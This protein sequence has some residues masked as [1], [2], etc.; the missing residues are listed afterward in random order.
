MQRIS[1]WGNFLSCTYERFFFSFLRK[2]LALLPRLECSGVILA[3]CKHYLPGLG[4]FPASAS[5]VAE[6]TGVCH[7]AWLIYCIFSRDGVSPCRSGWSRI[8]VVV[9]C[10]LW[11]PKVLGLQL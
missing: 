11:P 6:I 4:D 10:L 8:P 9:I 1:Y 5:K 7:H 2:S 3:R